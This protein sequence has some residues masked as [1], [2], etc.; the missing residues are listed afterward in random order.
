MWWWWSL[1]WIAPDQTFTYGKFRTG[2][3]WNKCM[4]MGEA[5]GHGP[6]R[7]TQWVTVRW[8]WFPA[9]H[10]I[11]YF[12]LEGFP[13]LQD[14]TLIY[15]HNSLITPIRSLQKKMHSHWGWAKNTQKKEEPPCLGLHNK[16]LLIVVSRTK[17]ERMMHAKDALQ[18][19]TNWEGSS[20]K[21]AAFLQR[22]ADPG[23]VTTPGRAKQD[24]KCTIWCCLLKEGAASNPWSERE[25]TWK[26]SG[27][28]HPIR[29]G[30]RKF[31]FPTQK[32]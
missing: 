15:N 20:S 1:S 11:E 26:V 13:F 4:E 2:R 14:T 23:P 30:E 17:V 31:N 3:V 7:G 5:E 32:V 29:K 27:S 10:S 9:L 21:H 19:G 22:R 24:E 25:S 28:W 8:I 12:D 18:Q 16:M 6:Q